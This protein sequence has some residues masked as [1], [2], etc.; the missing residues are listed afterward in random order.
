MMFTKNEVFE[1][2][3][4]STCVHMSQT[5]FLPLLTSTCGR[6]LH[7]ALLK[8]PVQWPKAEIRLYDCNLFKTVLLV[9]YIT[10]L[11]R[12]KFPLFIPSKDE[13]LV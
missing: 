4:L 11:Y 1:P 8:R 2:P 13:I 5:L 3:P 7:I 12:R 9:I 10:N 6:H